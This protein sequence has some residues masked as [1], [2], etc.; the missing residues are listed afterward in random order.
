MSLENKATFP[1]DSMRRAFDEISQLVEVLRILDLITERDEA[2]LRTR[3]GNKIS[4]AAAAG[5][6]TSLG[7]AL[8]S[9]RLFP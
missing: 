3:L 4:K 5:D 8:N 1:L 6:K 9:C 2:A 7:P